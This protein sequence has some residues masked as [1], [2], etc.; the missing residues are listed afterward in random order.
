MVDYCKPAFYFVK[1]YREYLDL[2]VPTRHL[3]TT[4][5]SE[6]NR[7]PAQTEFIKSL[8]SSKRNGALKVLNIGVAQG[9]EPLTHIKSAFDLSQTSSKTIS[10]FLDLKTVD[11]LS[12]PP[13]LPRGAESLNRAIVNHLRN[14]YDPR[15]QKSFWSTPVEQF[16]DNLLQ[17]GEKQ[18]VILFNNVIQHMST[19]NEQNLPKIFDKLTDLVAENGIF[20]F[21]PLSEYVINPRISRRCYYMHT[22]LKSKNFVEVGENSGIYKKL[23]N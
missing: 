1:G 19:N 13:E 23:K 15:S 12:T 9:Q 14:I 17:K 10:D 7:Y 2:Q 8:M 4:C 3:M 16:V 6:F 5:F 11:I 22:I 21:T 18:D 20:C